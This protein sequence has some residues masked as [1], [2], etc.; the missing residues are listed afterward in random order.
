MK[1]RHRLVPG[2]AASLVALSTVAFPQSVSEYNRKLGSVQQRIQSVRSRLAEARRRERLARNQFFLTQRQLNDTRL[3]LAETR[4]RLQRSRGQLRGISADLAR[5]E[6]R[7]YEKRRALTQRLEDA[8]KCPPPT[9]LVALVTTQDAWGVMTRTRMIQQIVE[10][11]LRLLEEI[12]ESRDEIRRRQE[13]QRR[14]VMEINGLEARLA[15]QEQQEREL[16]WMHRAQYDAIRRDREAY[17][18]HLDELIRQSQRIAAMIRRMQATP[19]G[20]RRLA[21]AFRGGFIR[22]VSGRITSGFGMRYHPILRKTKLHTGVDIAAPAG[23]PILAAAAGTVII[24]EWM[25]AYGYT[26]VIDHGGGVSTLYG[27]CSAISVRVGQEVSQGQVVGRV[28]ST[29]W[30][31]GPHLH[32][33][34]RRN[35]QPVNPL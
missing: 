13:A 22:P 23:T 34:V 9:Y 18:R 33:E 32:W 10:S 30:S 8:Y 31:T 6:A 35:G 16:A 14:K 29:G 20:R 1:L 17:E 2:A 21:T 12:R 5:L 7:L 4:R 27:H 25:D 19:E 3:S 28:G 11:D 15:S 24:A 26:V